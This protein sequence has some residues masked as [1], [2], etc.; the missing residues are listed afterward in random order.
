MSNA[1]CLYKDDHGNKCYSPVSERGGYCFK[2]QRPSWTSNQP[3]VRLPKN[4]ASLVSRTIARDKGICYRCGGPGADTADHFIAR[5][6]G[7]SDNLSNLKAIH[8]K[9][10]PHCHRKKTEEDAKE[11]LRLNKSAP[12]KPITTGDI[13]TVPF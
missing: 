5:K 2:H 13:R 12:R 9:V 3:A 6:L 11:A 4:W 8:E 1:P 10:A 7:G